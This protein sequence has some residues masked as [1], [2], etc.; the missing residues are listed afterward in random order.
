MKRV[1]LIPVFVGLTVFS[2]AP[3]YAETRVYVTFS[4][5]GAVVIG[6]GMVYWSISST[7][8]VSEHKPSVEAMSDLPLPAAGTAFRFQSNDRQA[9]K[10]D[11]VLPEPMPILPVR[12]DTSQI[13]IPLLVFRW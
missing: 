4:V 5:G 12:Q 11:P 10:P 8:R 9:M 7:S 3:S 6:A 2:P 13:E 1:F